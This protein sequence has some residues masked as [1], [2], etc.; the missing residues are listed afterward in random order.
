[1]PVSFELPHYWRPSPIDS[2]YFYPDIF[3]HRFT[4]QQQYQETWGRLA[5]VHGGYLIVQNGHL[6]RVN[7]FRQAYEHVKGL[8]G[9]DNNCQ[10]AKIKMTAMKLAYVGYLNGYNL[11]NTLDVINQWGQQHRLEESF[12]TDCKKGRAN[13]TSVALQEQLVRFYGGHRRPLNALKPLPASLPKP[14]DTNFIFGETYFISGHSDLVF[15]LDVQNE[16]LI[17]RLLARLEAL[18]PQHGEWDLWTHPESTGGRLYVG[19]RIRKLEA[20]FGDLMAARGGGV[21]AAA[22]SAVAGLLAN[23]A[24]PTL[25]ALYAKAKRMLLFWPPLA[26]THATF[27]SKLTVEYAKQLP[28]ETADNN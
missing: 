15:N 24:P 1:V 11:D 26:V 14:T 9:Y 20:D 16:V 10:P 6:N 22:F 28:A 27:L 2:L 7:W 13:A 21:L 19:Y 8:F 25:P 18:E 23:K 3:E 5:P 17:N 12:I 4:T